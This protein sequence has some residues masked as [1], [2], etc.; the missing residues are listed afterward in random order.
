M[1]FPHL[2]IES[3]VQVNDKTRINAAKTYVSVDEAEI[4]LVEIEP[5]A[6]AGYIDVTSTLYLDWQFS[7]DGNKVISLR[8]TTDGAPQSI[9]KTLPIISVA[10]DKLFSSDADLIAYEPKILQWVQ[11]GRNSFLDVHRAAQDRILKYLD[12]NKFWDVNGDPLTKDAIINISEFNDWSKF[13]VLK[14][15]FE[16]LSNAKDDI[17]REKALIYEKKEF[18]A[19]DRA[20]LRVDTNDDGEADNEEALEQRSSVFLME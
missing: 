9:T 7:T 17:F 5:G 16:G 19:R 10:N 2:E 18:E 12:E 4:T 6:G 14:L 11:E 13:M 8:V 1:I 15:I 20:V 3:I